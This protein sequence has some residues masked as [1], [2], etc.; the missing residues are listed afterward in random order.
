[1]S[2]TLLE[3]G[4]YYLYDLAETTLS[5]KHTKTTFFIGIGISRGV[6]YETLDWVLAGIEPRVVFILSKPHRF[7]V[8]DRCMDCNL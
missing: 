4:S 7:D 2:S 3:Y 6:S 1:M 5:K 8:H